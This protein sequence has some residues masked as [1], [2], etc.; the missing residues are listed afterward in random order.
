DLA[1]L[2]GE[3][4]GPAGPGLA[5]RVVLGHLR[6]PGAVEGAARTGGA[7]A[8][9]A[10][11]PTGAAGVAAEVQEGAHAAG[12]DQDERQAAADD[13]G[14]EAARPALLRRRSVRSGA[15]RRRPLRRRPLRCSRV[16]GTVRRCGPV[17]AGRAVRLAVPRR[18]RTLRG[19]EGHGDS[20][21]SSG[22]GTEAYPRGTRT[23][24]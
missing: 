8:A 17:R 18:G 22:A 11:R 12:D 16:R 20:S 9:G 19:R 14:D 1:L 6:V 5:V 2:D 15:A 7:P 21:E 3:V 24:E 10:P 23:D 4:H 13:P